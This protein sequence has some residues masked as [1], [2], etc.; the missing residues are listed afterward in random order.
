MAVFILKKIKTMKKITLFVFCIGL[1]VACKHNTDD[2]PQPNDPDIPAVMGTVSMH[3]HNYIDYNEVDG[4]GITYT[5][6]GGR[7]ITVNAAQLFLSQ[8]EFLRADGSVYTVPDTIILKEEDKETYTIAQIPVGNYKTVRFHVGIPSAQNN[9]ANAPQLDASM[10]FAAPSHE[11]V[12]MK[13]QGEVDSSSTKTASMRPFSFKIGTAANYKEV[14]MP[15]Q[16]FS[17]VEDQDHL[18]HLLIDYNKLFNG[19]ALNAK[20]LNVETEA[21]NLSALASQVA[22]NIPSMFKY[23]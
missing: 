10:R 18:I 4:Y 9:T 1:L 20:S 8:F 5:T 21:D 2:A 14:T 23:E 3:L 19:I 16:D 11:Y 15:E 17:V 12:F 6:L 7:K 22:A 13:F